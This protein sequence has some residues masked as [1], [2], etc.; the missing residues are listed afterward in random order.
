MA[1]ETNKLEDKLAAAEK[2]ADAAE[3]REEDALNKL[4]DQAK[5]KDDQAAL[6]AEYE[7][8]ETEKAAFAREKRAMT[9]AAV[10][11]ADAHK[12]GVDRA[13][14]AAFARSEAERAERC[15][16]PLTEEDRLE[17]TELERRARTHGPEDQPSPAEMLKLGELRIRAKL[18]D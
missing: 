4:A 14:K 3:K 7:D 18:G 16:E 13:N 11:E 1:K 10:H 8:L 15:E 6:A 9:T 5:L 17:L 12:A 2:R